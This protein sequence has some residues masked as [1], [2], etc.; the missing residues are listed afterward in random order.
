LDPE[1]VCNLGNTTF[2]LQ[3]FCSNLE[4]I[5]SSNSKSRITLKLTFIVFLYLQYITYIYRRSGTS[6]NPKCYVFMCKS[7]PDPEKNRHDTI[8]PNP[9]VPYLPPNTRIY[10]HEEITV[11]IH[12]CK[13]LVF[14]SHAYFALYIRIN[15]GL[16]TATWRGLFHIFVSNGQWTSRITV[17]K[18][19]WMFVPEYFF[20]NN[21]WY[22]FVEWVDLGS[23][24]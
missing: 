1:R 13:I 15:I 20:D 9:K 6:Q 16:F 12:W 10:K 7:F 22:L 14:C 2:N 19:I 8:T 5:T 21:V 23:F 11:K 4:T 24:E 3:T 17:T 18:E